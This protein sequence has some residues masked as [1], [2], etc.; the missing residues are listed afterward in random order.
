MIIV[1]G[2]DLQQI[3]KYVLRKMGGGKK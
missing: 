1:M 3:D 2:G